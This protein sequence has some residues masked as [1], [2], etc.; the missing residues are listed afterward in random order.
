LDAITT[1]LDALQVVEELKKRRVSLHLIDLGGDVSG[2]GMSKFFLTMV[3]AF[4]E[5]ERHRIRWFRKNDTQ[6]LG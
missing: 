5:M 2:N 1:A 6:S 3:A 4:A